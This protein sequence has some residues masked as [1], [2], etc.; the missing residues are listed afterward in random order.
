MRRA[1][2]LLPLLAASSPGLTVVRAPTGQAAHWL[3]DGQS[4]PARVFWGAPGPANLAI[5]PEAQA[6]VYE[7]TSAGAASNGTLHF[8]FGRRPGQIDLDDVSVTD[9]D[10]GQELLPRIDFEAGPASF[11]RDWTSWPR[12]AANTVGQVAVMKQAG[13]DGSAG[14]RVT[15]REPPGGT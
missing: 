10:T 14:L 9:L 13:R 5:G 6:L 15:L 11:Q 2:L 8:R 1:L 4:V 3:V 7:F 12:D